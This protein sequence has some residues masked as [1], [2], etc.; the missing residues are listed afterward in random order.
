MENAAKNGVE[1]DSGVKLKKK[2]KFTGIKKL[3]CLCRTA[4]CRIAGWD[5]IDRGFHLV[6]GI[7]RLTLL[8][9]MTTTLVFHPA[10]STHR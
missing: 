1:L 9:M 8:H 10:I 7:N 5:S 6:V 3:I 4:L 2:E